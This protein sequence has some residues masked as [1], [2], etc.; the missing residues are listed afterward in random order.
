MKLNTIPLIRAYFY[1][2]EPGFLT[3][4]KVGQEQV[5][6]SLI[7]AFLRNKGFGV[8]LKACVRF[9]YQILIF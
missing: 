9:F 7:I 1:E 5:Y 2:D 3:N 6:T 4:L 8:I